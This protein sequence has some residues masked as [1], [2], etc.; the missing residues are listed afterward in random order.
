MSWRRAVSAVTTC[1]YQRRVQNNQRTFA[2]IQEGEIVTLQR[3]LFA[4]LAVVGI[5]MSTGC[6]GPCGPGVPSGPCGAGGPCA[7]GGPRGAC[8]PCA[9]YPGKYLF[10]LFRCNGCGPGPR[11]ACNCGHEPCDCHG[12]WTGP[13]PSH[14][15]GHP[16]APTPLAEPTPTPPPLPPEAA[17]DAT[18]RL[19]PVGNS[20][21]PVN[22]RNPNISYGPPSRRYDP[23][24]YWGGQQSYAPTSY[25]YPPSSYGPP[26]QQPYAPSGPKCACGAH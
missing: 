12:D 18:T 6:C 13:G 22:Y 10:G 4:T 16:I 9:W 11:A 17:G 14:W 19:K 20:I 24:A 26:T 1:V 21:R 8:G 25:G 2:R 3:A 7:V 5:S 15:D 23:R